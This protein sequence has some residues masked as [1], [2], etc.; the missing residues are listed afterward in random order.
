MTYFITKSF[1]GIIQ[2]FYNSLAEAKAYVPPHLRNNPQAQAAKAKA[3]KFR[4]EYEKPSNQRQETAPGKYSRISE[5]SFKLNLTTHRNN[6]CV[7]F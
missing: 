7:T 6:I 1:S 4:E 3:P 5:A 2:F